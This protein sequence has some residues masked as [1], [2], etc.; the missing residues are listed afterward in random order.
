MTHIVDFKV[1]SILTSSDEV[2]HLENDLQR[3]GPF[4][5]NSDLFFLAPITYKKPPHMTDIVVFWLTSILTSI[6]EV[7]NSKIDLQRPTPFNL[8]SFLDFLAHFTYK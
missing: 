7:K 3:P 4:N 1:T 2:T 5:L 6:D 8:T